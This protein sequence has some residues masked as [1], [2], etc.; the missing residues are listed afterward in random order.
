MLSDVFHTNLFTDLDYGSN[1]LPELKLGLTAGV[2]GWQEMFTP[3]RHLIHLWYFQR[4][5][6]ALFS[7]LYFLQFTPPRHLI[8]LWYFQRSVFALF[9]DLYFLHFLW[10]WLLF[11]I[12]AI[13]IQRLGIGFLKELLVPNFVN[14]I[15]SVIGIVTT[16]FTIKQYWHKMTSTAILRIKHVLGNA[17][18][19]PWQETTHLTKM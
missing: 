11:I 9:S 4:S 13:F 7:D 19:R 14:F 16:Y 2:T 10:D 3:P 18:K 15:I 12:Y 1:R 6:F 8:H 17:T 5:V